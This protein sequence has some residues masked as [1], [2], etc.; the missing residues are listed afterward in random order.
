MSEKKIIAVVGAT[1]EQGGA[2]ARALLADGEFA[3]RALAR[4][5][6]SAP[7]K[8]LAD[9]GAEVVAADLY[10]VE[11]LR[12]G[13][14]GAYGAYLVTPFFTHMS[15]A[16]ELEEVQ[17]LV[18]AADGLKHVVWSTLEDT[19]EVISLDDDR[20]PTLDEKYKV[21]HFDVKGGEADALFEKAGLPTTYVR[22]SFY[23]NNLLS[24]MAPRRAEDGSL[25][26]SLPMGESRISGIAAEDIGK[27]VV[28]VLKHP[29]TTI[30]QTIGLGVEHLTGQEVSE[31]FSAVLGEAVAYE[32]LS[33]NDFRA[34][35]FRE[36]VEIGNMFQYYT[37][38][39]THILPR[40]DIGQTRELVPG[41]LTLKEFLSV[42]REE[43]VIG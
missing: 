34:L 40:R 5:P 39:D 28:G 19:R 41:W 15:A 24:G 27:A 1:G 13:F 30:G 16:K 10:D 22:L 2:V 3:V 14:A 32:P 25:T 36:A 12:N 35:G 37:E 43:I 9:L 38:F 31:A 20:M 42:H 17:N 29:E 23:W 11:S 21:P 26:L 8:K 6:E 4:N 7:A 33:H 18:A